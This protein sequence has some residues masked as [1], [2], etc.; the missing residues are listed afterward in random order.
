[1]EIGNRDVQMHKVK[2]KK[3]NCSALHADTHKRRDGIAAGVEFTGINCLFL[4]R[5]AF[6]SKTT[7]QLVGINI[8]IQL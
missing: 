3:R 7:T 4:S 5:R 2:K 8:F 6:K 1:M